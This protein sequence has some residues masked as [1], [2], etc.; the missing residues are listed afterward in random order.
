MPKSI[1]K[2]FPVKFTAVLL[3]VPLLSYAVLVKVELLLRKP[4]KFANS[5]ISFSNLLINQFAN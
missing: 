4:V 5:I 3:E 2:Q 1:E